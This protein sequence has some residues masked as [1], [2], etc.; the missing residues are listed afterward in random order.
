MPLTRYSSAELMPSQTTSP[1]SV[2]PMAVN[3]SVPPFSPGVPQ[4]LESL[5][6]TAIS[7]FDSE[8][9]LSAVFSSTISAEVLVT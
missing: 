8:S 2:S 4:P 6:S 7:A 1:A 3:F 5:P 9:K